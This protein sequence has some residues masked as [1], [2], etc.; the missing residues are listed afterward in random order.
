M[1]G[2]IMEELWT[3]FGLSLFPVLGVVRKRPL[4][5]IFFPTLTYVMMQH[6]KTIKE[7]AHDKKMQKEQSIPWSTTLAGACNSTT[8]EWSELCRVLQ[9]TSAFVPC[10]DLLAEK[11]FQAY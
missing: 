8:K 7:G 4:N 11:T 10:S 3:F 5:P 9:A 2:V 1:E 6:P